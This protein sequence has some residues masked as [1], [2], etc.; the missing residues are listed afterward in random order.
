[1]ARAESAA[2]ERQ[3]PLQ[4]Q[5]LVE[6]IQKA[7]HVL[8]IGDAEMHA[9]AKLATKALFDQGTLGRLTQA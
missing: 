5:S 9:A 7:P 8:A 4:A 3:P 6:H 2:V 1:M